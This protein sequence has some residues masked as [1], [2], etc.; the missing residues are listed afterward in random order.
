MVS[1]FGA[2]TNT[3]L[4]KFPVLVKLN[5]RFSRIGADQEMVPVREESGALLFAGCLNVY[6]DLLRSAA[7]EYSSSKNVQ[8]NQYYDHKNR[9]YCNHTDTTTAATF[10]G[11]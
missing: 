2:G 4:S 5:H 3:G 1:M 10:F 9:D 6:V 11:H 8:A 7:S